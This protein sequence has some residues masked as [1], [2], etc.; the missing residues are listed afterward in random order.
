M[1]LVNKTLDEQLADRGGFRVAT[2]AGDFLIPLVDA[3]V[4][5]YA[6]DGCIGYLCST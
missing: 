4:Q 2:D 3:P 6:K 1:A 5:A